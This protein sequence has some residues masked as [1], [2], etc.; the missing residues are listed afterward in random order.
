MCSKQTQMFGGNWTEDKLEMLRQYLVAYKKALKNQPFELAYI[1]AFAGTGYREQ[2]EK[3]EAA[4][5]FPDL[6][7]EEPQ[8]FLDGSARLALQ[9]RPPFDRYVFIER[10]Q[11]RFAE[12]ERLKTGAAEIAERIDL[13]QEDCNAALKDICETW[14]WKGTRAVLFMDP[15]GMQVDWTTVEAIART[16]AIDVWILFPLGIGVNRLLT[17]SGEI[18]ESWRKRLDSVLGASD[19]YAEFY[20]EE[21]T[22]GLFGEEKRTQKVANFDA[23]ASYYN[24]RLRSVFAEVADNP[25]MLYNSRGNP[26]FLLCFAASNPRGAPITMRIAQHIL[27]N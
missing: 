2:N 6:V 19:W 20:R 7:G 8:A 12:L 25:K 13:R 3:P 11:K 9:V 22:Q 27:R 1:D 16:Q 23:I 26:L 24:N 10:S 18:R 5:L 21:S 14:S 4:P 15:F 17:R